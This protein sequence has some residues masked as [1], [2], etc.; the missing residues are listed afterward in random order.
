M[1]DGF[2]LEGY[3][4]LRPYLYH[5]LLRSNVPALQASRRLYSANA[6]R[7]LANDES[8]FGERRRSRLRLLLPFGNVDVQDHA[9]LYESNIELQ[10]GWTFRRL[11]E[12]IDD[13]VF[14][15]PGDERG[16]TDY[17]RRHFDQYQAEALQLRV[18]FRLMYESAEPKP[19]FCRFNSGSPR[20]VGGRK[21]PRGP[22]TFR[23]Y[24]RT[25]YSAGQVVEVTFRESVLLPEETQAATQARGPWGP[26]WG[27]S[28]APGA[29]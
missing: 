18:P 27:P 3:V 20:C 23:P 6:L 10:G 22:D 26:V 4:A 13:R 2:H 14:F 25:D 24:A 16:P 29:G 11:I 7:R 21:S 9:P 28:S 19:E 8:S 17:G 5:T 15:W 1:S 12:E